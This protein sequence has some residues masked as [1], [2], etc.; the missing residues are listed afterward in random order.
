MH[1]AERGYASSLMLRP[2]ALASVV[3]AG[4]A[5]AATPF[6][7]RA[8]A[9]ELATVRGTIAIAGQAPAS[10]CGELVVEARGA[11]DAHLIALT[12]PAA[13]ADG[14]CRYALSVPAQT[15]VWLSVHTGAVLAPVNA[16]R[17]NPV[18]LR[19]RP[20]QPAR[21]SVALRFTVVA[22]TTYFFAPGEDTM[23][24]LAFVRAAGPV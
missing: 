9:A 8:S 10:R 20:G 4:C 13:G 2:A 23:V 17:L 6:S 16:A 5:L 3:F 12:Q 1:A 24:P 18:A 15:A 7:A 21:A 11:L 14:A 19:A 22:A